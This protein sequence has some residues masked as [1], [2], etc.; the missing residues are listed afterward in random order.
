LGRRPPTSPSIRG[1]SSCP[2]PSRP[3]SRTRR[4]FRRPLEVAALAEAEEARARAQA[5][6]EQL[7]DADSWPFVAGEALDAADVEAI[8]LLHE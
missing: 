6:V 8:F 4:S 3:T 7:G 5:L 1:R 2:C